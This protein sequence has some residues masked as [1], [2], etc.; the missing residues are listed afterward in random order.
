[1]T[2]AA[3][4]VLDT[5]AL[6]RLTA[7]GKELDISPDAFGWLRRSAID[8]VDDAPSLRARLQE[9]GYLYLPGYLNRDEV[10]AARHAAIGGGHNPALDLADARLQSEREVIAEALRRTDGNRVRAAKL[11][12]IGRRTLQGKIAKFG[13]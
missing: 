6:P 1:M 4:A 3:A 7:L 13:L 2:T 5:K 11:L 10:L 12:N 8:L 9:D